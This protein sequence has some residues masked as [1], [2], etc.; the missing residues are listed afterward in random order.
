LLDASNPEKIN[1]EG[2]SFLEASYKPIPVLETAYIPAL[3]QEIAILNPLMRPLDHDVEGKNKLSFLLLTFDTCQQFAK[4]LGEMGTELRD[5][6]FQRILKDIP[7]DLV[8]E[9][10]YDFAEKDPSYPAPANIREIAALK[11][12]RRKQQ[13]KN[14]NRLLEVARQAEISPPLQITEQK[15]INATEFFDQKSIHLA[16]KFTKH[17]K[18]KKPKEQVTLN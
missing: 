8:E 12:Y 6:H 14:L 15:S 3:E 18:V 2:Y 7:Y 16:A 10:F 11:W 5:N 13:F 4:D 9:S 1:W 17:M